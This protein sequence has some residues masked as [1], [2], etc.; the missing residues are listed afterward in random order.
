MR[1]LFCILFFS[2]TIWAENLPVYSEI[3]PNNL[4]LL[5]VTDT[6]LPNVS[7]RLYY[8]AGS[9]YESFSH[10][11]LSH[12]FEHMM[13]KGTKRLGTTNYE[14][15]VPIMAKID[16]LDT[17]M[18]R[19]LRRGIPKDDERVVSLRNKVLKLMEEQR[20]YIIKD[21]I[22][23]LY[24]KNGANGL[25]AWTSDDMTA[26]IVTLPANKVELFANIESDRMQNVVLR[27]FVSE[28]DVVLEER[29]MRYENRPVNN[30]QLIL[31]TIFY[32]AH[33]YQN[34]TIGWA[35]DI[36]NYTTAAMRNHIAK[37]YRPDNAVIILAGN[38]TPKVASELI[39]KYFAE[40]KNPD[41]E[42]D[43]V[44]TREPQPIGEKRF[45]VRENN[46]EP[47]IDIAF[48]IP[49][50]KD[51]ALFA[52]DI[53]ENMLSGTSGILHKRLVEQE[54]LCLSA[55]AWNYWRHH[56]GKF[57]VYA[58]L[59]SGVSHEKVE[60][61]ILEEIEKLTENEPNENELLRVKNTLKRQNLEKFRNMES[62]SDQLA[63]FAKF[64]NWRDLF[65]YQ[66]NVENIKSTTWAVKKYLNPKFRVV[67][68]LVN[69]REQ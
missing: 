12:F 47:R 25:N 11:G 32:S 60:Q 15:E 58:T 68:W 69:E 57:V 44:F 20:K 36:A 7:C 50:Y 14:A 17:E 13:F 65:E 34:P 33:P 56:N 59:K 26:Y 55:G 53:V 42:I 31:E 62:F 19:L 48:H 24:E 35:S 29:R 30:Y 64:G 16:T 6:T 43:E 3:L 27:E 63:F 45:I 23:S 38:I 2:A 41:T 4:T 51:S 67:G 40:I 46:A 49:G 61:I 37:F 1:K 5:V 9:M 22:W 8:F 52:L 66:N 21:E 54:N 28:R 18:L 39:N 10:T